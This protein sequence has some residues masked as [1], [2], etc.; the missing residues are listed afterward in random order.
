MIRFCRAALVLVLV[1]AVLP[2]TAAAQV[3]TIEF[4]TTEV[5][6][7]DLAITPDG[8]WLIF[9]L[10]GHL[11]RLP[12]EGGTAEQL[13]FGPYFDADIVLSPDGERVAFVSDRDGSQGNIFMLELETGALAQVTRERWAGRPTFTPDGGAIVYLSYD[14]PGNSG[15]TWVPAVVRRVGL[16]DD[17]SET[18]A[19]APQL[20]TST[21][22]LPDGR[23]AWAVREREPNSQSVK[24][25]LAGRHR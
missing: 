3:R 16:S 4:E 7:P 22:F 21:F 10:L 11:F 18:V 23:L 8:E 17:E 19:E 13:T 14:S 2:K 20:F 9:T 5:T 25:R 12:V 24:T 6:A 1:T 15:S